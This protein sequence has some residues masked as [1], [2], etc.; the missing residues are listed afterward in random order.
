MLEQELA[1]WPEREREPEKQ[2]PLQAPEL[3]SQEELKFNN[4]RGGQEPAQEKIQRLLPGLELKKL[5]L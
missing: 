4:E 2:S 5:F 3:I 1:I